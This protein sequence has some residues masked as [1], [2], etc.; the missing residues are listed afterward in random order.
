MRRLGDDDEVY[1]GLVIVLAIAVLV[2]GLRA[3]AWYADRVAR[4][5]VEM[6]IESPSPAGSGG[7]EVKKL[8]TTAALAL[9][10]CVGCA[11]ASP[12]EPGGAGGFVRTGPRVGDGGE[13]DDVRAPS[14]LVLADLVPPAPDVGGDL[15]TMVD[16][17]P[18]LPAACS[19]NDGWGQECAADV[20]NPVQGNRSCGVVVVTAA[21]R[22]MECYLCAGAPSLACAWRYDPRPGPYY[23]GFCASSCADCFACGRSVRK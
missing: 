1:V 3:A 10:L 5:R 2:L 12:G 6:E 17:A 19:L 8:K 21:G 4:E 7:K 22:G 20:S 23:S 14:D 18:A 15:A 16:A 11:E 13:L 9:L